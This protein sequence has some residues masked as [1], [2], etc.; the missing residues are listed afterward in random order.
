MITKYIGIPYKFN[1]RTEEGLDCYGLVY[2]VLKEV[3][4]TSIPRLGELDGTDVKVLFDLYRPS[5]PATLVHQPKDGD[6]VLL[7]TRSI[8]KHIGV[9]YNQGV[10]HATE[11]RG[12]VYEKIHSPFLRRFTNTEF[13]RVYI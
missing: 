10:V 2:L 1:G 6:I 13:Y 3:F 4:N 11:H 9:Y 8:P 7:Y 5:I 12:V